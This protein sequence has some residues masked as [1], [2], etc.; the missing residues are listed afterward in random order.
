MKN[1]ILLAFILLFLGSGVFAQSV[2]L[3]LLNYINSPPNSH[4][5]TWVSF[6]NA[7]LYIDAATPVTMLAVGFA[8]DD[9]ELKIKGLNTGI[10]LAIA[11]G[12]S[13]VLKD[14]TKR[15]RPFVT[16]PDI[17]FAKA[18]ETDYSFPSG[19]TSLAFATATSL[20]MSFPKWY[21]IAPS[22]LYASA[23]GYSRLYLGVHYPSDVFAGA[24]VGA[25][26]AFLT[27]KAQKW[28]SK[29]KNH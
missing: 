3:R 12:V 23:V 21:V 15:D 26:S 10:S 22:F 28:L 9:K 20:S 16:Y 14:I 17:I 25:G 13:F 4:D 19:H 5:H 6:T 11:G 7:S 8:S 24:V 29:K 1:K 27:F 18:H 2:D